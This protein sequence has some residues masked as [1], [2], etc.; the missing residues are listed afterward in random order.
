MSPARSSPATANPQGLG[1][2]FLAS[3]S[4][5]SSSRVGGARGGL[6]G[7]AGGLGQLLVSR[8][9]GKC[10]V[11]GAGDTGE[12]PRCLA[13]CSRPEPPRRCLSC[14]ISKYGLGCR[15]CFNPEQPQTPQ[16]VFSAPARGRR[17]MVLQ[18]ESF[19]LGCPSPITEPVMLNCMGQPGRTTAP[20][21]VLSANLD[22][23]VKVS[24]GEVRIHTQLS[25]REGVC[26]P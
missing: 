25:L 6:G 2:S 23:A 12:E 14:S 21:G 1:S 24:V 15:C 9:G 7:A 4:P 5:L 22:A 19:V 8:E 3:S 10:L 11:G 20:R 13:G 18:R 26:P 16:V 17:R